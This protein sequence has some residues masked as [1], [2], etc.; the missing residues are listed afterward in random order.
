[1]CKPFSKKL[2]ASLLA[3]SS[4]AFSGSLFA[5]KLDLDKEV[6]IKSQR[7]AGDLKN[8]IVTYLDDVMITQGTL[9]IKADLVQ[10]FSDVDNDT[11]TYVAKG[12]PASFEQKLDDGSLITLQADEIRYEPATFNVTISGNAL[13]RQAGSEVSGSKIV[14][15]TQTEQLNAESGTNADE[16]VTTILKPKA[17]DKK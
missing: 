10:V 7:L 3:L 12:Q 11:K 15:N 5:A 1:M 8:K 6:D 9:S 4:F 14:Y 13:L 16:S 17:K 2:L